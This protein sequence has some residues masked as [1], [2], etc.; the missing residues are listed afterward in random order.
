MKAFV[1]GACGF[2]GSHLVETL[3]SRGH[4]VIAGIFPGENTSN[5][6]HLDVERAEL[7]LR[8]Q[9]KKIETALLGRR[10][11]L[12][13]HLAAR[14]ADWGRWREFRDVTVFGTH[15]LAT[16][17]AKA[18]VKRFILISS[19]AVLPF[20]N[21]R[22]ADENVEPKNPK[23]NYGLAKLLAE[24][25]V[26]KVSARTNMEYV[27]VRP[28]FF[29]FGP[30]DRTSFVP[31]VE[32]MKK[33]KVPLV[34]GGR[35]VINTAYVENLVYGIALCA[36]KESAK[37]Q[38][39]VIADDGAI[40]WREVLEKISKEVGGK[41]C[42]PSISKPVAVAFASLT[43]YLWRLIRPNSAPPLTRYRALATGSSWHFKINK[44]KELLG[45]EPKF[46][47]EEGLRRT[48]EWYRSNV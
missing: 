26:E 1:T 4:E 8:W 9:Y 31:L 27:I 12:V 7:D 44:A 29:P 33:S 21:Y 16:A 13:F 41:R 40:S 18:N 25:I 22:D 23:H 38:V 34:S 20:G 24:Q 42:G 37:N 47:F 6:E 32:A 5:I 19:L 17:A 45:Y 28:G 43:E 48:F 11:D 2:I 39:F 15:K 36:E 14:V 46:S 10:I 35:N 30:R 3:L